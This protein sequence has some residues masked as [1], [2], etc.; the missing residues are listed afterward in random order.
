MLNELLAKNWAV[1]LE[2]AKL[3]YINCSMS[4]SSVSYVVGLFK[5][6]L[7]GSFKSFYNFTDL[8]AVGQLVIGCYVET[9]VLTEVPSHMTQNN[10]ADWLL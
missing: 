8:T 1:V 6:D 5:Q 4:H 3:K 2:C 7:A 10:T 9:F